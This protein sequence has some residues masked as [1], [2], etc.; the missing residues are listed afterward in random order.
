MKNSFKI[1]L[2]VIILILTIIIIILANKKHEYPEE[3][4]IRS[5]EIKI[6]NNKIVGAEIENRDNQLVISN[7]VVKVY[8][9]IYE[10]MKEE[11]DELIKINEEISMYDIDKIESTIK[12]KYPFFDIEYYKRTDGAN[13]ALNIET[14]TEEIYSYWIR[15]HLYLGDFD[16]NSGLIVRCK[17]GKVEEIVDNIVDA[18][19]EE[20]LISDLK[21]KKIDMKLNLSKKDIEDLKN[22]IVKKYNSVNYED[23]E[24]KIVYKYDIKEDKKY[25]I[26][27]IRDY[28]GSA[29]MV[30]SE[31]FEIK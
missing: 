4:E 7:E 19:K 22:S 29:I 13:T 26:F 2:V 31:K 25:I 11:Y 10:F 27:S 1:A 6:V 5:G 20:K 17:D 21:N 28:N 30:F 24:E 18:K 23:I 16:A 3:K 14:G 9:I 12:E 8:S 15:Y